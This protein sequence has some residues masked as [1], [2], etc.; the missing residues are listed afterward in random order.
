M[1]LLC[2]V[3]RSDQS[4]SFQIPKGRCAPYL[5]RLD[6]GREA[7]VPKDTDWYIQR[8]GSR[9]NEFIAFSRRGKL[10][11]ADV[12]KMRN[13]NLPVF[14]KVS[15]LALA[16]FDLDRPFCLARSGDMITLADPLAR[17]DGS[18]VPALTGSINRSAAIDLSARVRLVDFCAAAA[19]RINES[20]LSRSTNEA[21]SLEHLAAVRPACSR[22]S[23]PPRICRAAEE[24]L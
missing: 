23:A 12:M 7:Y 19:R 15:K 22:A 17:V 20:F 9:A 14:K 8:E 21:V 16:N 11:S 13:K 5:V 3:R 4:R 6:D 1:K 24:S 18:P 2:A 10:S